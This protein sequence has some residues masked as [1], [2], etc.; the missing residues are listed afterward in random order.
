MRSK[1]FSLVELL[2]VVCIIAVT[3]SVLIPALVST[4]DQA[5]SVKCAAQ[6]K[7]MVCSLNVYDIAN[8]RYPYGFYA[9]PFS[10]VPPGGYVGT[11]GYDR[12]G[13]WWFQ[14]I[15]DN[16]FKWCPSRDVTY[17]VRK[18]VLCANYG[19]NTSICKQYSGRKGKDIIG[20]PLSAKQI[21]S[22]ARTLLVIDAGYTVLCWVNATDKPTFE[23][24]KI[25]L[26]M[27][28]VPGLAINASKPVR[29]G[30][31]RD[32]KNGRHYGKRINSGFTDGHVGGIKASE[33]MVKFSD[34]QYSNKSPNWEP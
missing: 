4:R 20:R 16:K 6:I 14:T 34:G 18:N 1:G 11:A 30:T 26:D 27:A 15:N 31:E 10:P 3:A 5:K 25:G 24:E 8:G 23:F 12:L 22:P 19:I 29:M 28:Y 21:N 17:R 33:T 32:S 2:V 13:T 9:T 7:D